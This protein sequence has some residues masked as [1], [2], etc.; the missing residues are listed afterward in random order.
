MAMTRCKQDL[1]F[2]DPAKNPSGCPYC[3]EQDAPAES[4]RAASQQ[5]ESDDETRETVAMG[6]VKPQDASSDEGVTIGIYGTPGRGK[7]GFA[8]VVGWLVCTEGKDKG[9]DYRIKPGINE[10]GRDERS[11]IVVKGDQMISRRDHAVIEF[12]PEENMFYLER[13]KNPAVR[14]NGTAV[15]GGAEQ[16]NASDEVK[17]GETIFK[18]IPFCG[19]EADGYH[20]WNTDE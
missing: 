18:F 2:Y 17:L 8:P 10:V 11:D 16:L 14:L 7:K 13:K 15:R 19:P 20:Q 12:D 9:K 1:H 6:G 5:I 3:Q 4:T